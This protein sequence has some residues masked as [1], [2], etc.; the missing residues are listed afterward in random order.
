MQN[1]QHDR[2]MLDVS[3]LTDI[4]DQTSENFDKI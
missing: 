3:K 4:F 2:R 1:L